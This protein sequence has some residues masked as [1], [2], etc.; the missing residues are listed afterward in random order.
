MNNPLL[1]TIQ[2]AARQCSVS[3]RTIQRWVKSGAVPTVKIPARLIRIPSAA[4]RAFLLQPETVS[5]PPL[6]PLESEPCA[7]QRLAEIIRFPRPGQTRR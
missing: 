4:L 7:A 3:P 5:L 6:S 2:E 1:W